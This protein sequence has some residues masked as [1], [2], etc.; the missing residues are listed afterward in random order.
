MLTKLDNHFWIVSQVEKRNLL[1]EFQH[2]SRNEERD[3]KMS[4]YL[5]KEP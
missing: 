1:F 4:D 3:L 2:I 5:K